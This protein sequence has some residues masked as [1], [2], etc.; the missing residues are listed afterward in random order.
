MTQLHPNAAFHHNFHILLSQPCPHLKG[1]QMCQSIVSCK[2][3]VDVRSGVTHNA[4]SPT[5]P[6]FLVPIWSPKCN[7][8][9]IQGPTI[10]LVDTRHVVKFPGHNTPSVHGSI[11]DSACLQFSHTKQEIHTAQTSVIRTMTTLWISCNMDFHLLQWQWL[12]KRRRFAT[13]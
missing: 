11:Y 5:E 13:M 10:S 2:T 12:N 9:N 3:G 7:N 1:P 6:L 4:C 8:I